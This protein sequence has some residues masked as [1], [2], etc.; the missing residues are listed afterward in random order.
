MKRNMQITRKLMGRVLPLAATV[1]LL[2]TSCSKEPVGGPN[3]YAPAAVT[4][5]R[6]QGKVMDMARRLPA[7]GIYNRT[8]DEILVFRAKQD[9]SRSF[10]FTTAPASSI[11]FAS[12]NGGQWV[13]TEDGGMVVLTQ[14]Q[15]GLG[16]GG[17]TVAAG[18][19][20]LNINLAVCFATGEDALG[21]GLFGPDMGEVAGVIGISGDFDALQNGD[22][23]DGSDPFQ[24]FHG[25][26]YY[27]VYADQLSN[28]D[29]DVLNWIDDLD[30]PA[31]DLDNFSFAFVISFQN[32]G[33]IYLSK[34]GG[35]TV[36]GGTMEFNGN[37]Y[38]VEGVGFFDEDEGDGDGSF[39]VV[40]GYG[41]MGCQ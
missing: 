20:V 5:A 2:F 16:A 22:F 24:Y 6:T 17:G 31:E 11:N 14:P 37:Y 10:D 12:S 33:G 4:D 1:A 35:I 28:T 34:D 27:F 9:G 32:E 41:A 8:M 15:A 7:V 23:S 21:G 25:F 29:Y 18:N 26:A 38:A 19:T 39:S 30:Q 13:W 40:S 3:N 36:N